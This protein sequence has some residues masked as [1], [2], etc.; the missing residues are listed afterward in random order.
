MS[1]ALHAHLEKRGPLSTKERITYVIA[2]V[3]IVASAVLGAFNSAPTLWGVLP[4]VLYAV[5]CLMGMDVVIATVAAIIAGFAML[6]PSPKDAGVM[7]GDSLAD[8]LV[9]IGLI[10]MLGAGV[11][12]VLRETGVAEKIVRSIMGMVGGRGQTAISIGIMVSCLVLVLSLGTLAGALAIAAP[13]LIPIAARVGFTK[14]AT[15]SMMFTGGCAG[16]ALAPFAGSNVVIMEAAEVGYLDFVIY[17]AGPLALLT[18]ILGVFVVRWMQKRTK[19]DASDYYETIE[20]VQ[21]EPG[22]KR[23]VGAATLA[24]VITLVASVAYAIVSNSGTTFPLLALPVI[25]VAT[26]LAGGLSL[27]GVL[28]RM[29]DGMSGMISMFALFWLLAVLFAQIDALAPFQVILDSFGDSLASGSAYAFTIIIALLGWVGVP[30]GTAAQ[31]VLIDKVFGGIGAA[32]GVPASAW[33]IV[34]L[35]ASKADTYGPFPN[36]NMIGAMGLAGSRNLK[37][38]IITGWLLLV[39][40]CLMYLIILFFETR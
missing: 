25:A 39:P 21:S 26:G 8:S 23:R 9:V 38:M 1:T 40:T 7:L 29:Y 3:G 32:L 11:G 28:K 17:G 24:F 2:L 27:V 10:I 13:V 35:F 18:M 20:P 19:D 14:S 33:V 6:H 37:N 12:E 4:I 5:L 15:A 16:L 30:G 36:G 22:E 34:L 31:V